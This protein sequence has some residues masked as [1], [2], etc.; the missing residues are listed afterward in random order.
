MG[1]LIVK[2]FT[3][4]GK[5]IVGAQDYRNNFRGSRVKS[6]SCSQ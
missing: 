2:L 6:T 3:D 1:V 5:K 4:E